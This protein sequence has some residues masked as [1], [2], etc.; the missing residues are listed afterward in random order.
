M[1]CEL[2]K[3]DNSTVRKKKTIFYIM[4]PNNAL[5]K[6]TILCLYGPGFQRQVFKHV[7]F[8]SE[9]SKEMKKQKKNRGRVLVAESAYISQKAQFGLVMQNLVHFN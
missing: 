6:C 9:R 4:R 1:L 3:N 7:K 2:E 5:D 8:V